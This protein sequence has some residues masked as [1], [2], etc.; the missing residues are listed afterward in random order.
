[1]ALDE[2]LE[3]SR[4]PR[5]AGLT[6]CHTAIVMTRSTAPRTTRFPTGTPF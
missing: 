1:M 2:A 6:G 4:I 3:T 5:V